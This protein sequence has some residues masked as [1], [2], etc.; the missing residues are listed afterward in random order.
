M[1]RSNSTSLTT[2][3][4][5]LDDGIPK[6]TVDSIRLTKRSHRM[7]APTIDWDIEKTLVSPN[8][9]DIDALDAEFNRLSMDFKTKIID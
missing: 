5:I 7:S 2:T 6:D 1:N 8:D 3:S 9:I 4:L